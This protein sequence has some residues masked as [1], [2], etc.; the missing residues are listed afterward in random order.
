MKH[1]LTFSIELKP[2]TKE[3][4]AVYFHAAQDE[5]IRHF[6]PQKAKTTEEALA[7]YEKTL[8][9]GSTSFGR[10]VYADSV[11]VGDV[12]AY[13]IGAGDPGTGDPDAMLSFCI[14]DKSRWG[15]GIASEAVGLFLTE[16]REK[17]RLKTVGAF[18]YADNTASIRV[19][20]KNRFRK[21]ESFTENGRESNYFQLDFS[22]K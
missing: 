13:C 21:A 20:E 15:K 16:I 10:C 8:L 17:Y 2:R 12:W 6:L 22:R 7:E 1:E 3:N 14:F 5:E 4:V 19:L 9:P 18:T 11:Y